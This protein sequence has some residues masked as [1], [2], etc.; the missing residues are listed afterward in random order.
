[1]DQLSAP[2]PES[3]Y[4]LKGVRVL[5][6]DYPLIRKDFPQTLGWSD[7]QIDQWLIEQTGFI[8]VPQ[9]QQTEVNTAI[10]VDQDGLQ[11][12]EKTA[13][14]PSGYNSALVFEVG[15]DQFID[16]KGSGSLNPAQESHGNG[17][18]TV[19]EC[20]REFFFEKKVAQILQDAGVKNQTVGNYAVLSF[21]FDIIHNDGTRSPAGAVLRQAHTRFGIDYTRKYRN[22]FLGK[23]LSKLL[24]MTLR[25]YGVTSSGEGSWRDWRGDV[26]NLQGNSNGEI[27]DFG[28]YRVYSK[29]IKPLFWY[30]DATDDTSVPLVS[31]D[32]PDFVQPDP[33][34]ALSQDV[35]GRRE[36]SNMTAKEEGLS[37]MIKETLLQLLS[38]KTSRQALWRKFEVMM[39]DGPFPT[40]RA[41]RASHALSLTCS[42]AFL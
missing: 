5:I 12:V 6:A 33:H 2:R 13:Y 7:T 39:G 15:S 1:L 31:V 28:P 35:W 21:G 11:N 34:L 42:E 8:S 38:G 27:F 16:S 14:R 30:P 22:F 25:K 18:A 32:S 19:F 36:G 17:L 41:F 23:R 4:K 26:T 37:I 20:V 29:F 10:P 40:A 9:T 3:V 24:E